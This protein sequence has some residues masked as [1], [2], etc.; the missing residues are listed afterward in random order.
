MTNE[1]INL[2]RKS[3]ERIEPVSDK[4]ALLFYGRLFEL[5][6]GLRR[7]FKGDL[8]AQGLKLMRMI[9]LAVK[10]L[11]RL[12]ELVPAVRA[13]GVKHAAYGVED[14]HYE[15]VAAAFLWTLEKG[16]G[17]DFTA[18]TKVAWTAVYGLLAQT[19]KAA[20]RQPVENATVV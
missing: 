11:D 19:M 12:E 18:P 14:H 9:G 8:N 5:D 6:P 13:L 20:S 3:F 10:G 2:V 4:A 15:T 7:L 1:Q 16:L 17:A